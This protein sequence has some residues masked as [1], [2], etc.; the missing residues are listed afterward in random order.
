LASLLE[1]ELLEKKLPAEVSP[2][3][4]ALPF[5]SRSGRGIRI[6]VIDSGV[7]AR[8]PHITGLA[9]GLSVLPSG[10]EEGSYTDMLGHGTAVMAAIQEKAPEAQYFAVRVFHSSLRTSTECLLKAIEWAIEQRMDV[11]NLSLGT[12]NPDH[13]ARFEAVIASAAKNNVLLVAAREAESELC[14]PG[15]LP[16]VFGVTLDWETPRNRYRCDETSAGLVYVASGYPRSLPGLPPER[17]LHGISFA[18]AN[19]TGFIARACEES[20][21]AGES[22]SFQTLSQVLRENASTSPAR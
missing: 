5:P 18:V 20:A 8:H 17:N 19:M 3:A 10:I 4:E 1:K 22:R 12:R 6:A 14:F 11:V 16:G 9:G 2:T 15:S 21:E 13:V 7:N